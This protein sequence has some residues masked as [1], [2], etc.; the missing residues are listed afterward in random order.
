[1]RSKFT[2][3]T[4]TI[5]YIIF[6]FGFYKISTYNYTNFKIFLFTTAFAIVEILLFICLI[7]YI[8]NIPKTVA[9]IFI[10]T[11]IFINIGRILLLSSPSFNDYVNSNLIASLFIGIPRISLL[12]SCIVLSFYFSE[13]KM[14]LLLIN[15]ILGIILSILL[16]LDFD[17]DMASIL[18]IVISVIILIFIFIS[19]ISKD[20]E[21]D[22]LELININKEEGHDENK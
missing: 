18:R 7:N 10:I 5:L 22:T 9:S 1:M 4:L 21:E 15:S 13:K 6:N 14:Y 3:I 17:T 19:K 16:Y 20:L 8:K 2:G 11:V 12:F